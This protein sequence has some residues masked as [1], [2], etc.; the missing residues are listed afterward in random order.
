VTAVIDYAHTPDAIVNVLK[1]IGQIRK[2]DEQV[3]T[4]IGAGGNRDKTKRPVMARLAAEMSDKLILTSDNP[5]NEDPLEILNDMKSGLNEI[6]L[7]R[8]M[9]QPDRAEAIK[10]ACML[11]Q[12]GDIVLIAGKGHETYQEIKGVKHHFSDFEV[13]ESIFGI[14]THS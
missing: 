7:R 2:K 8:T 3:I 13:V 14:S 12:K 1:T 6:Q 10:M 9:I 5:R 11:A 4:V